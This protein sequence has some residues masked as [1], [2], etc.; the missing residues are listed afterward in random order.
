M[1]VDADLSAPSPAGL[2]AASINRASPI[3]FH[4]QLSEILEQEISQ[5]RW[6]RGARLPPE[7]EMCSHFGLSRSTVRHALG[8]LEQEGL[9]RRDKGHGA[10]VADNERRSWMLQSADGLFHDETARLGR[11]VSSRILE[12]KVGP[13]PRWALDALGLP[14]GAQGVTLARVR[15][16]D[17]HVVLYCV[18]HL[19]AALA[20]A[21]LSLKDPGESLYLRLRELAG[22]EVGG[23]R[24]IL[25][26]VA[27]GER[28]ST[29]L[30]VKSS[31]PLVAIESIAWD[32]D[33][34]PF[35]CFRAWLRTD[36]LAIEVQAGQAQLTDELLFSDEP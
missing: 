10:Y 12:L 19:P 6:Q 33:H 24:R 3:P 32:V 17:G 31:A 23:A 8:R 1:H 21:V 22:I 4:F 14:P 13:L 28:L 2:P 9:I 25:V 26:A 36:R 35:D 11:P 20:T 16:V 15:A 5:R 29:L 27:A 7:L 30:E 34:K 18:N